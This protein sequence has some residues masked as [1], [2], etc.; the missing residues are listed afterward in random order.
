[1]LFEVVPLSAEAFFLATLLANGMT[2]RFF[3]LYVVN[4]LHF[5]PTSLLLL[6]MVC[7]FWISAF[8]QLGKPLMRHFGRTPLCMWLHL[9]SAAFM[10]GIYGFGY[11]TPPTWVVRRSA[12]RR[13][14]RSVALEYC[15]M[16]ASLR[17]SAEY[18]I[19]AVKCSDS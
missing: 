5:S 8:A 7:R 18:C 3:S 16:R 15:R 12:S 6:N 19:L 17:Y 10:G 11:F 9:V 14:R 2:V 4:L 13:R 1:M